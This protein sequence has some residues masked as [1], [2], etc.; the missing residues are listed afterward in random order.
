MDAADNCC[1]ESTKRYVHAT[2]LSCAFRQWRAKSHCRFVHGYALSFK[3]TFG[4]ST[5]DQNNWCV[6]FGS[7]KA[8]KAWLEH[9]FD[10]KLL[11]ARDDPNGMAL[12]NL[13]SQG[14]AQTCWV[15]SVGIESFAKMAFCWAQEALFDDKGIKDRWVEK[16]EVWEHE[17]NSAIYRRKHP[18]AIHLVTDEDESIETVDLNN[19]YRGSLSDD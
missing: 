8:L 1:W 13:E 6:D 5:L 3:F 7:L 15:E 10:H 9:T 4:C 12:W 16:V 18:S 2:G 14:L 11:V 19:S 17:A